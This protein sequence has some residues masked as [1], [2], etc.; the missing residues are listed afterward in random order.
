MPLD[1]GSPVPCAIGTPRKAICCSCRAICCNHALRLPSHMLQP[2]AAPAEPYAA[3][4]RCA[5]RVQPTRR[6][7]P[8]R[9]ADEVGATAW[10][11]AQGVGRR[12]PSGRGAAR[13]E[14]VGVLRRLHASV[15][16]SPDGA[17]DAL[18]VVNN[19]LLGCAHAS[20][21]GRG[22]AHAAGRCRP[23][24]GEEAS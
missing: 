12:E 1:G 9:T 21:S 22:E 24:A 15:G 3:A 11:A 14:G 4:M 6:D 7:G 17:R 5:C 8:I 19:G 16:E 13:A 10:P 2:Y 18:A 23:K 20:R